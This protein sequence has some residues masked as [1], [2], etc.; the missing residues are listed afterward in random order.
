[1]TSL[2]P[3]D[4][5]ILEQIR[6]RLSQL[7]ESL[8]SL[9]R[10]IHTVHPLPSWY[11][12][13]T[14]TPQTPPFASNPPPLIILPIIFQSI[15]RAII[16]RLQ[17]RTSLTTRFTLLST[18]LTHLCNLL[19]TH[20]ST[21]NNLSVFPLPTFPA[22]EQE[23][24]LLQLLRKKLEPAVEEWVAEGARVGRGVDVAGG[25]DGGRKEE[26]MD[27]EKWRELWDWGP[28]KANEEAR[29][30]EW[31][32]GE[33]TGEEMEGGMDVDAGEEEGEDGE[34]DGKGEEREEGVEEMKAV[35]MEDVL[36]FMSTGWQPRWWEVSGRLWHS[37]RSS[38]WTSVGYP[39]NMLMLEHY[40]LDIKE[41]VFK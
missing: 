5:R 17:H 11:V 33:W 6:Q 30:Y 21:L 27:Q 24:V 36:R 37:V 8:N 2:S 14:K 40:I 38:I 16:N 34:E 9:N 29:G 19:H 20:A 32:T 18:H 3:S 7:T 41:G 39:K 1:M 35:K 26:G 31:F 10:D 22:K 25:W 15:Y 4:I 13:S 23:N 12:M 28:V